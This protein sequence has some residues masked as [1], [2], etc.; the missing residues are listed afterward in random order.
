MNPPQQAS[1]ERPNQF[2]LLTQRRFAPFF[3][4]Q[5]LGAANDNLFKFGL[6]V[7][8]T[9]QV[10]VNW[11]PPALAGL[12]ISALFILPYLLFS[13]TA[14]Q[15]ADKWERVRLMRWV[16]TF[17]I[18]IMLIAAFGFVSDQVPVLLLCTFMMGTHSAVFGPAKYAYL[19]QVL[20]DAE[21]TGGTGMV[22]MGTFVAILLGQLTGGLL[23]ATPSAH[24]RNV[25][26]ACVAVAVVGRLASSSIPATAASDPHIRFNWNPVSETWRNLRQARTNREVFHSLL[27]ISW[28]WFFGAVFLSQFPSL[29]HDVLHGDEQVASMLLM[30]FSVGIGLGSLLCEMLNRRHLEIGLVPLAALGMSAFCVDLYFALQAVPAAAIMGVA[31]FL[32][33][34]AHWRVIA[35]LGLLSL[36]T[37][38]Y[39]V[40]MYALIQ[41]R[42]PRTH[43]ARI[44]AANN[45]LNALFM[46][47]SSLIAAILLEAGV[48]LAGVFLLTGVA[49][50][51]L[52]AGLFALV[53]E[54][55]L[56][57][58]SWLLTRGTSA[59]HPHTPIP[60]TGAA[61]LWS[62]PLSVGDAARLVAASPRRICFAGDSAATR[63]AWFAR[64][65]WCLSTRL[66]F[67]IAAGPSPQAL[68]QAR[69]VLLNGDVLCLHSSIGRNAQALQA[70]RQSLVR[71]LVV[72]EL[73]LV[74]K[75]AATTPPARP[76]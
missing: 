19:P 51:A 63:G 8:V 20:S 27:G 39:S 68:M 15:L 54:Y 43:R 11:L 29:A 10:Q 28:M 53:P 37:G 31:A 42:S 46:I 7:M 67:D 18:F 55:L 36:F 74:L 52:S 38:I 14:G 2:A 50:L 49:N 32:S 30:V 44:I 22:E 76:Q 56:R 60:S 6:I 26:L 35:D 47:A 61:L 34:P 13:A 71:E 25:A 17:E 73:D 40:P 9:Y 48:S 24:H 12:A 41:L 45:I 70:W 33:V 21:L 66:P 72:A 57:C 3:W 65:F 62:A 75:R 58:I 64:M 16:K 59:Q 1:S 69:Q 23:V 4:T 5:F